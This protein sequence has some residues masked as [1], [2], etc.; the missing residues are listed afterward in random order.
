MSD[1]VLNGVVLFGDAS[2][3][4]GERIDW[5]GNTGQAYGLTSGGRAAG[6]MNGW[7][8]SSVA[9][10]PI[11]L[12]RSYCLAKDLVCQVGS[13]TSTTVHNS[14][15]QEYGILA[16]ASSFLWAFITDPQRRFENK[17]ELGPN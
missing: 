1:E 4:P 17:L 3:R 5:K 10:G 2:Y 14:Y 15:N 12:V 16:D 7:T 6:S 9:S 11:P 8:G 13:T